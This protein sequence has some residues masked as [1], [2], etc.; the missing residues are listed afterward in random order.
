[1]KRPEFRFPVVNVDALGQGCGGGYG[2][3]WE[4]AKQDAIKMA[5]M[6]YPGKVIRVTDRC[7]EVSLGS[8]NL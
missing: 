3:T 1:M 7:I 4:E 5:D 2:R 8:G 6:Y